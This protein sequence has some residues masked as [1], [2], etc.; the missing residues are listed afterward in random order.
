MIGK[1]RAAQEVHRLR[2]TNYFSM[3]DEDGVAQLVRM[4]TYAE[5]ESIAVV[6]VNE[7]LESQTERPTPADLRALVAIE[8]EAYR[9]RLRARQEAAPASWKC[10]KCQDSGI[11][12]GAI[13][14]PGAEPWR[15][16]DCAAAKTLLSS[17]PSAVDDA[18]AVRAKLLL[19]AARSLKAVSWDR[20]QVE[21]IYAEF[22]RVG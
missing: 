13:T 14:G 6:V 15:P 7:W 1:L 19:L 11:C 4:L 12:G 22:R 16:C 18:N 5:T 8:N 20:R 17:K 9:E 10:T 21:D 3:L 2:G